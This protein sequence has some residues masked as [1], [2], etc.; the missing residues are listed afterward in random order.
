[1]KPTNYITPDGSY[2]QG[3]RA[4]ILDKEVP[5]RPSS[6][7]YWDFVTSSW[8][9]NQAAKDAADAFNSRKQDLEDIAKQDPVIS[10]ILTASRQQIRNY[11]TTNVTDIASARA[12][13]IK[14]TE[15]VQY[16]LRNEKD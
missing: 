6:F 10:E 13:L 2:Y 3:D 5:E 12:Y 16:I 7:H 9:L 11:I 8:V 14:L 1:M 15:A 4:H